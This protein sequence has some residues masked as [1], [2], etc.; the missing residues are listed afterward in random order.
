MHLRDPKNN[1]LTDMRDTATACCVLR[2]DFREALINS[3]IF[4]VGSLVKFHDTSGRVCNG[5]ACNLG[6][7]NQ[8]FV[9][10]H[11]V[12]G[13]CVDQRSHQ[14]LLLLPCVVSLG[15]NIICW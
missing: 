12:A 10:T 15:L 13:V 7:S 14:Q 6:K 2:D 4:A 3:K 11:C 9:A 5:D 1:Y 8:A